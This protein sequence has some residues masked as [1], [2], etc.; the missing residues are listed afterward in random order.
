MNLKKNIPNII[1][2][3]RFF[4]TFVILFLAPLMPSYLLIYTATGMT[5][6]LDGFIA[7]KTNTTSPLGERLDSI[8]DLC[9]Y[10]VSLIKL[11]PVLVSV[12]PQYIWIL[13][14]VILLLRIV[15]YIIAAIKFHRFASHH[16]LLNKIT[17]I[18]VFAIPYF[19]L[20]KFGMIFCLL[21]CFIGILSTVED[22]YIH[23]F[24]TEYNE[25]IKFA[26]KIRR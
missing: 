2:V 21:V 13:V 17:G 8:A 1:T 16:T 23:I 4:G 10:T 5:D 18:F 3:F 26:F 6:L 12:L 15:S 20:T 19:L 25:N 11:L 14:A 24:S 9:F 22:L 7:R